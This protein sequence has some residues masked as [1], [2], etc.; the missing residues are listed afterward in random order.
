[1]TGL[2]RIQKGEVLNPK[3]RAKGVPNKY[4]QSIKEMVEE[5]LQRAGGV[6]YLYGQAL[7]NPKAFLPLVA[8]L[9]PSQPTTEINIFTGEDTI[10]RLQEGR[11]RAAALIDITPVAGE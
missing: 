7:L 5:A 8:K 10:R 4:T 1:V 9:L 11:D 6:E 2:A 3:G